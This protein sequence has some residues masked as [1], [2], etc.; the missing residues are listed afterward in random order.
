M[1]EVLQG[2]ENKKK[3]TDKI[4]NQLELTS[5]ISNEFAPKLAEDIFSKRVDADNLI[6][7]FM[8]TGLQHGYEDDRLPDNF[9]FINS[10]GGKITSEIWK[11]KI[12]KPTK[13]NGEETV[14][15]LIEHSK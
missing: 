3:Q 7:D 9:R 15:Y 2:E 13:L 6:W 10:G 8:Q 1:N 4:N 14:K 12:S 11:S 5:K